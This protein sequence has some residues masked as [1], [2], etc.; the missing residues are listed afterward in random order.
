MSFTTICLNM[1]QIS[2]LTLGVSTNLYRMEKIR[3]LC[4]NFLKRE[5]NFTM[6]GRM[7]LWVRKW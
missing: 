7:K 1:S 6:K 5:Y 2:S 3:G 4:Y